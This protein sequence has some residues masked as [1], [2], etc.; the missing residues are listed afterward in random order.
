MD[1][2]NAKKLTKRPYRNAEYIAYKYWVSLPDFIKGSPPS[3]LLFKYDI[4]DPLL[5]RLLPIGTQTE[6]AR[7]FEI[8]D[9]GTL[10]DWNERIQKEGGVNRNDAV[11]NHAMREALGA[12]Y[13]RLIRYGRAKD[14]KLFMYYVEGWKP[15][16]KPGDKKRGEKRLAKRDRRMIQNLFVGSQTRKR[17]YQDMEAI[18]KESNLLTES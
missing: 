9:L 10:T 4:H 14:F 13:V 6:F 18:M 8:K 2:S 17:F 7:E 5:L 16:D 1:D 11:V 15:G 12:L 3:A